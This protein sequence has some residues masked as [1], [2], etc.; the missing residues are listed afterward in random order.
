MA[1]AAD[2]YDQDLIRRKSSV[3]T[4]VMEKVAQD[5]TSSFIGKVKGLVD[6]S[7]LTDGRVLLTLVA[8]FL[9]FLAIHSPFV[10]LP[11]TMGHLGHDGEKQ[12]FVMMI[13]GISN[14]VGRLIFG[15]LGDIKCFS[16]IAL[17]SFSFFISGL[18][19]YAFPF[20]S[21]YLH[22]QFAG[23]FYGFAFS[24]LC[25]MT[26][27]M[28]VEIVGLDKLTSA[29]GML[30]LLRGSTATFGPPLGGLIYECLGSYDY[31]YVVN[32]TLFVVAAF[33]A[34]IAHVINIRKRIK[35]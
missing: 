25:A 9:V 26:T 10:F 3:A 7:L 16:T 13:M 23:A 15:A 17:N 31:T 2:E 14:A 6:V 18:A 29:M 4:L 28:L 11:D 8:N 5:E 35:V 20:C 30:V 33:V 1:E 22:F 24:G 34:E 19:L 21:T 12:S 32:G 27:V